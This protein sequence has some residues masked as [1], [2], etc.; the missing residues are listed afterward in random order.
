MNNYLLIKYVGY[1]SDEMN[2][3]GLILITQSAWEKIC[4]RV[5]ESFESTTCIEWGIGTNESIQFGSYDDWFRSFVIAPINLH[6]VKSL[7][8]IFMQVKIRPDL[9]S[10]IILE[11]GHFPLLED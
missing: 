10:D 5:R 9:D 3:Y 6:E 11:F 7:C 1:W 2:I 8:S 4:D